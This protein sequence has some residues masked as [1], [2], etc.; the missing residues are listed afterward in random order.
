VVC[1]H[2]PHDNE[3]YCNEHGTMAL[4]EIAGVAPIK[5]TDKTDIKN[6]GFETIPTCGA[7]S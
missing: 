3:F 7:T 4:G 1:K 2:V 6:Y 5:G